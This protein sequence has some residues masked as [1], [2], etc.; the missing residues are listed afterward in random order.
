MTDVD[1][2][3]ILKDSR[4]SGEGGLQR[5]LHHVFPPSHAAIGVYRYAYRD[6]CGGKDAQAMTRPYVE[7]FTHRL[8]D[9]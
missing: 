7:R 2:F 8:K 4:F 9:T 6:D 1:E 5:W 3:L